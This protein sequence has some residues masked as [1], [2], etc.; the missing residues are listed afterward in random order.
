MQIKFT[1]T[2]KPT[3]KDILLLFVSTDNLK[4]L[5]N[6]TGFKGDNF[7]QLLADFS[8]EGEKKQVLDLPAFTGS[9]R[10]LLIGLGAQDKLTESELVKIGGFAASLVK[11]EEKIVVSFIIDQ[12]TIPAKL[13]VINNLLTGLKL[14]AWGFDKYLT[15]E[16][17]HLT[18]KIKE[19]ILLNVKAS[20]VNLEEIEALTKGINTAKDLIM[21]PANVLYPESFVAKIK[22]LEAIGVQVEVLDKATLSKKGLNALLSVANGSV[23]AP[24]V[25]VLK[26]NNASQKQPLAFIGKGVTFDSGGYSLKTGVGM[27]GMKGDMAGAAAVV[28]LVQTLALRKAK[29]NVVGVVGLVENLVNSNATKP[30]DI[31]TSMSGK[32]IEILNTDAEGRLVLADLLWYTQQELKPQF[33]INLATLTYAVIVALGTQRAGLF[34]NNS[35]LAINISSSA[36]Q[37]GELVWQLPLGEE[38]RKSLKSHIADLQNITLDTRSSGSIFAAMFLQEFINNTPWAHLDIAGVSEATSDTDY[39][40]KGATGFGVRLLNSLV[41]NYYEG[42]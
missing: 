26:Y 6:Y 5:Q 8:F 17:H 18:Y 33:M 10:T 41:K 11:K 16:K 4:G 42:D 9:K 31:I 30:G 32:T 25:V 35:E 36:E 12:N 2:F 24:Y 14:K 39:N 7:T 29:V 34:S 20:E 23:N 21:E 13:N 27:I 1:N 37:T 28:G 3:N 40:K 15:D 38:Y 22:E 19:I